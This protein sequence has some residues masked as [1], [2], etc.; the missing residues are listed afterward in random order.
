MLQITIALFD[1]FKSHRYWGYRVGEIAYGLHLSVRQVL[2]DADTEM[3][4]R[5]Q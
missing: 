5:Q 4:P 3:V 2:D 1:L